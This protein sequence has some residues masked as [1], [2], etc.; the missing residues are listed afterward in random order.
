MVRNQKTG[1][2]GDFAEFSVAPKR[3]KNCQGYATSSTFGTQTSQTTEKVQIPGPPARGPQRRGKSLKK[4][5][6][7][8]F[9]KTFSR[10][11]RTSSRLFQTSF[12]CRARIGL[13]DS[14]SFRGHDWTTGVLENGNDWRKFRVVPRS[15]PLHPLVLYFV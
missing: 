9:F 8:T 5:L 11:V 13:R 10:L 3:Q 1:V 12:G 7:Q 6:E 4:G 2:L 14:G 15:H